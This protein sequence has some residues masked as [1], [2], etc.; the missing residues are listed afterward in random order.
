MKVFH[1]SGD[2]SKGMGV[3]G[4]TLNLPNLF[5]K[6]FRRNRGNCS[7]CR[8]GTGRKFFICCNFLMRFILIHFL[9]CR[10]NKILHHKVVI[11]IADLVTDGIA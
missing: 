3:S 10:I 6:S 4:I 1:I 7:A 8:N 9:I 5:G 2:Q 11:L